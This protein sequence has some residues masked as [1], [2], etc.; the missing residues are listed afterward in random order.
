MLAFQK[1]N[2]GIDLKVDVMS[3]SVSDFEEHEMCTTPWIYGYF[4]TLFFSKM[5]AFSPVNFYA[6]HFT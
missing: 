2:F 6:L 1:L 5:G 4:N 3:I